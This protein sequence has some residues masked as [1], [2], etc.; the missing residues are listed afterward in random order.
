MPGQLAGLATSL[1]GVVRV[2]LDLETTGLDSRRDRVRLLT[3]A[4]EEGTWLVD[5]FE[6]DPRPIFPVLAG[7]ELV[8]HNALFE[9]GFLAEMGFELGEGGRVL[10]TMLLSQMLEGLRP[11]YEEDR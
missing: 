2:A 7:K 10:D 3:L 9:L 8:A 11:R 1:D 6:V 4:T 5:C